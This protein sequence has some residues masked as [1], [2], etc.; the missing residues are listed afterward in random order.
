MN[1]GTGHR[2]VPIL[3]VSYICIYFMPS[4]SLISNIICRSFADVE[5]GPEHFQHGSIGRRRH[6]TAT[7]GTD[8]GRIESSSQA[9]RQS[10]KVRQPPG[11][12]ETSTYSWCYICWCSVY[13]LQMKGCCDVH[14]RDLWHLSEASDGFVSTHR[15]QQGLR[16]CR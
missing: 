4:I 2:S 6:W 11:P 7:D 8:S 14:S 9:R 5:R 16:Y 3:Q 12:A 10:A 15:F 13:V 1:G